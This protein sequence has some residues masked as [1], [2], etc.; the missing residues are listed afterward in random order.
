MDEL[1]GRLFSDAQ[2]PCMSEA[3]FTAI[4]DHGNTH[5]LFHGYPSL[6]PSHIFAFRPS[7]QCFPLTSCCSISQKALNVTISSDALSMTQSAVAPTK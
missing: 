6:T 2:N 1:Q 4:A 5:S 7:S 3:C